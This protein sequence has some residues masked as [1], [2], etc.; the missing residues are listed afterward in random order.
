MQVQVLIVG[1]GPTGLGVATRLNQ[2]AQT[3]WALLDQAR[4][5]ASAKGFAFAPRVHRQ[6]L[7]SRASGGRGGRP[8]LHGLHERRF[9]V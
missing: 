5:G 8:S 7:V 2:L 9:F 6:Y 3:D 4:G 1:A